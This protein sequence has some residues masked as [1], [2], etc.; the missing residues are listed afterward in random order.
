M[1]ASPLSAE[2]TL[3][4]RKTYART[5]PIRW[6]VSHAARYWPL[7]L[8]IVVGAYGNGALAAVVP[9]LVGQAFDD[10]LAVPPHLNVLI[11]LA[12]TIGVSQIIRVT[13]D[14]SGTALAC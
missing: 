8:M 5:T 7:V 6:I 2:F 1:T 10:M 9:G 11:P 12:V 3:A 14:K 4:Q 13:G